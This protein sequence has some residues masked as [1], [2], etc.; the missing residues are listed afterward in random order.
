VRGVPLLAPGGRDSTTATTRE[1]VMARY[2]LA[3]LGA[4]LLAA[5]GAGAPAAPDAGLSG[6]IPVQLVWEGT[7]DPKD[8]LVVAAVVNGLAPAGYFQ[9]LAPRGLAPRFLVTDRDDAMARVV[10]RALD[11]AGAHEPLEV[12]SHGYTLALHRVDIVINPLGT[13]SWQETVYAL[14]HELVE[15][16]ADPWL[17][18]PDAEV[19]DA[20]NWEG[21][22]HVSVAGVRFNA[23]RYVS[24]LGQPAC[25]CWPCE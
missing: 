18:D 10:L 15:A 7:W 3:V 19:A 24:P 22:T 21:P 5:C 13:A 20:C 11:T 9:G 2:I 23:P 25:Q 12:A 6:D 14:A 17:E 16:A 4:V 8:R 1:R